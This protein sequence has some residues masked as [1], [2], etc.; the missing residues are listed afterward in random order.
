MPSAWRQARHTHTD[1]TPTAWMSQ[2][3]TRA[4][5]PVVRTTCGAVGWTR[6]PI[7]V[8]VCRRSTQRLVGGGGDATP[9]REQC[10]TKREG[11]ANAQFFGGHVPDI[12]V[13]LGGE[14]GALRRHAADA[15]GEAVVAGPGRPARPPSVNPARPHAPQKETQTEPGRGPL[16][17]GELGDAV[18]A[19][20]AQHARHPARA[21]VA[22]HA[23]GAVG[24]G[25][26]RSGAKQP[27]AAHAK[28]RGQPRARR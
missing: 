17:K 3:Q 26:A 12:E 19:C 14:R 2:R 9:T 1:R 15:H 6:A 24:R 8:W 5:W 16:R 13:F 7:I 4:S 18:L 20:D 23:G 25:P 11:H 28:V 22:P 10:G 27:T 21:G